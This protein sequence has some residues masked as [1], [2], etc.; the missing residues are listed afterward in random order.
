M[1]RLLPVRPLLD[2]CNMSKMDNGN[3]TKECGSNHVVA[4]IHNQGRINNNGSTAT[5]PTSCTTMLTNSDE[6]NG[7]SNLYTLGMGLYAFPRSSVCT[8]NLGFPCSFFCT[9]NLGYASSSVAAHSLAADAV[10]SVLV[11]MAQNFYMVADMAHPTA[12]DVAQNSSMVTDAAHP[13]AARKP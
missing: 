10:L 3:A 12:A 11:G 1:G 9:L 4:S 8:S 2:E 7:S 13:S 6:F 5:A